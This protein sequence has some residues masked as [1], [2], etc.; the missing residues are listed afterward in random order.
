MSQ[1]ALELLQARF[2]AEVLATSSHRGD[3]WARVRP[4]SVHEVSAWLKGEPAL[5]M[6]L[7]ADVTAADYLVFDEAK[8]L[9][10]DDPERIEIVWHFASITTK[11]RLCLKARVAAG[12]SVPSVVDLYRTADWW[13]RLVWDFYGVKFDGHPDLRRIL[14]WE[15]FDGHP[16]RK[17]YPFHRRQTLLPETDVKDL[18]RGPGPGPSDRHMPF[19][20]RPGARRHVRSD[21]YD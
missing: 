20:Q 10:P 19:S 14:T 4:G 3:E 17:D 11:Q 2:P 16:L 18:V 8:P 15:S 12:G 21:S 6:K 1:R 13:E 5:D 7:L 9:A